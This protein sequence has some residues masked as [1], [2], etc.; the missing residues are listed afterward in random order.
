MFSLFGLTISF[1]IWGYGERPSR[2]LLS[3]ILIIFLSAFLYLGGTLVK[4]GVIFKADFLEA[5]YF[6]I[7]TFTTVGY[8]D[9]APLGALKIVAAVE[10]F[11]GI[12]IMPLFI[13]G[14]TRKYLRI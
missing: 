10:A 7:I 2:T 14:L 12:F 13:I 11:C 8:G 9:I 4:E 3:G 1:I 6:S 5:L